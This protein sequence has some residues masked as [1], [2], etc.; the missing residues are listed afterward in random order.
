MPPVEQGQLETNERAPQSESV[1]G[2]APS[3]HEAKR[4]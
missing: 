2:P 1:E 3:D 4:D